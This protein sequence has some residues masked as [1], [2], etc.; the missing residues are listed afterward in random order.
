MGTIKLPEAFDDLH[1]DLL[2]IVRTRSYFD[3][4]RVNSGKGVVLPHQVLGDHLAIGLVYDLPQAM[5]SISQDDLD[6]WGVSFYEA[7]EAAR[8]NLTQL[9]HAFHRPQA[10]RGSLSFYGQGRLRFIPTDS[11]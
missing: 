4:A 5:R 7:L 9:E 8:H 1:P 6:G 2:P 11:S 3:L 10:G